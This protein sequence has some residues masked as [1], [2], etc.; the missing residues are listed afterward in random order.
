MEKELPKDSHQKEA[1]TISIG[2]FS[3]PYGE[4][5]TKVATDSALDSRPRLVFISLWSRIYQK[6][7]YFGNL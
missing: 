7:F 2:M 4:R 6:M 3:S 5:L 1:M